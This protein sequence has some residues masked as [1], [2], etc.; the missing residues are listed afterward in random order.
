[1]DREKELANLRPEA[2][3]TLC[4]L[5]ARWSR[6]WT[7]TWRLDALHLRD[8]APMTCA[9]TC[10]LTLREVPP[11]AEDRW[12]TAKAVTTAAMVA[13][14]FMVCSLLVRSVMV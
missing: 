4:E 3:S 11:P 2:S 13:M 5:T 14:R 10:G 8:L 9:E 6:I 1:M 7:A 12:R